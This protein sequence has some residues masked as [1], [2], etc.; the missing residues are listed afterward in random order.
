MRGAQVST[1][2]TRVQPVEPAPG[3]TPATDFLFYTVTRLQRSLGRAFETIAMEHG[4]SQPELIA[5]LVL[6]EGVPLSNA[7]L[8]RRTF[9]SAQASHELAARLIER[10]LVERTEHE[11]N[12]RVRLL[13]LTQEGADL[14]ADCQDRL[15]DVER[16]AT[17][18]LGDG[19]RESMN[20]RLLATALTLRGGYFGDEEADAAAAAMRARSRRH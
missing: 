6:A 9:V 11:T 8:A 12:R 2:R 20:S 19:A 17:A 10:G 18:E 3:C 4:L 7:Q 1:R 5:G 13:S 15:T 14:V 16:R